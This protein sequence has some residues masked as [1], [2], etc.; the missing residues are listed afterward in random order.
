MALFFFCQTKECVG[1][2]VNNAQGTHTFVVGLEMGRISRVE[3]VW[4]ETAGGR[5]R[6]TAKALR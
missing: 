6:I 2:G 1:E 3:M 5:I 4:F